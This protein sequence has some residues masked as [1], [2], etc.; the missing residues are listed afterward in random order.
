MGKILNKLTPPQILTFGFLA[1]IFFGAIIL[2]LPISHESGTSLSF[3]DA[4]FT[5]VSATTITGLTTVNVAQTFS[6]FGQIVLLIM[7]EVGALG[8]MTFA[9]LLFALTGRRLNLK[10]RLLAQQSLNLRN[11]SDVKTVLRYVFGLAFIIQ[12]IGTVLLLPD[13]IM[14]FG[15]ASG[16]YYSIT[17]TISAFGNAGFVFM[18]VPL[19]FMQTDYYALTVWMLLITAGSFG[20]L[21]WRDVLL[22]RKT[23]RMSLH[24]KVS[25]TM[26]AVLTFGGM[27]AFLF[28]EGVLSKLQHLPLFARVFDTLYL[29]VVPRTAGLEV[30]PLSSLSS[31]GILILLLL[32]FIGGTPGSTSGGIKTTTA[33]ILFLQTM[34][35][36]RGRNSVNFRGRRFSQNNVTKAMMLAVISVAFV[37]VVTVILNVTE[38]V[39]AGHGWEYI[40]FEVISAFSTTG[41]SLGLTPSLTVFGKLVIMFVMFIGRVG[42]YTVMFTVLNIH[43]KPNSFEY[44][45]EEVIIG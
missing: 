6:V 4:L 19:T 21:V 7:I 35:A 12:L 20:F 11:L 33:A 41:F 10:E 36:L 43:E 37:F 39:P 3:M 16:T 42:V 40:F 34:A 29:A 2:T 1:I 17:Q 25:L 9:V 28:T 30:I 44:P 45:A 27:V 18:D 24:T 22:Y 31:A 26:G 38:T 14:R 5:A 8:F 32:M 15:L 23:K 13:Y